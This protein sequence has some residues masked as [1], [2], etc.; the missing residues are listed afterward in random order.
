[1]TISFNELTAITH[2]LGAKVGPVL[3]SRRVIWL[4]IGLGILLRT[5]QYVANRSLWLDES[6]LALN[7]I[8]KSVSDLVLRTLDYNQ[9]APPGFLALE[10]LAQSTLGS[11]EYSLRLTPLL[12]AVLSVPLFYK[13]ATNVIEPA[14]VPIAV[15][16]FGLVDPLIYYASE[17]KQYSSD[18]AI[19]VLLL[20]I[21]SDYNNHPRQ[22]SRTIILTAVGAASIWISHPALF[23]LAAIG[24][25]LLLHRVSIRRWSNLAPEL[26]MFIAWIISFVVLY[27]V[28]LRNLASH[29]VLRNAWT[30][31]FAPS[32]PIST[33]SL[34]WFIERFFYVIEETGFHIHIVGV[35]VLSILVG[36]IY[37]AL[38]K[39]R[40]FLLII[41]PVVFAMLAAGLH[42][43]PFAG[44]LVLFT[45]PLTI[46]LVAEGAERIRI[47][48]R[49]TFPL[50]GVFFIAL[51]LFHSTGLALIHLAKPR[52]REEI[53]PAINYIMKAYHKDDSLYLP[54]EAQFAFRYY[55]VRY[56]F[57]PPTI[58]GASCR[59]DWRSCIPV[60]DKLHGRERVWVV[61][62]HT[63]PDEQK[64]TLYYLD[65]MGT[66]V[67]SFVADG[68]SV[69]LYD[70]RRE[71]AR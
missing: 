71:T 16:L 7:V 30:D 26:G 60:L 49:Q 40:K 63:F 44:R 50:I 11:S 43:Y 35:V 47:A 3:T 20:A 4:L 58:V 15:A 31:R 9:A 37:L 70:L 2:R 36:G 65:T 56:H 1:M 57:T 66:R 39:R 29:D 17:L 54:E 18:V 33:S 55:S 23:A 24:M 46:L 22:I 51:L 14:A 67:D 45:V 38:I 25:S 61:F 21:A 12:F 59:H 52:T 62:A 13:L 48:T 42:K 27:A 10:K 8:N 6:L 19:T 32:S 68:A 64:F 34:R 69:Y 28:S 41:S 53:R 5:A